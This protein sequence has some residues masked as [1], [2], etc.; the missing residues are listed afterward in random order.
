MFDIEYEEPIDVETFVAPQ[1]MVLQDCVVKHVRTTDYWRMTVRCMFVAPLKKIGDK[2]LC[3][4][5]VVDVTGAEIKLSGWND[6]ARA[7]ETGF[8][9]GA[10]YRVSGG[11]FKDHGKFAHSNCKFFIE[12]GKT[13]VF[14][15]VDM[16]PGFPRTKDFTLKYLNQVASVPDDDFV[17]VLVRAV[18][19]SEISE[20]SSKGT[21]IL[22]VDVMDQLEKIELKFFNHEA[23]DM[24]A[25]L[26]AGD[27]LLIKAAL[28]ETFKS[29]K[30]LSSPLKVIINPSDAMKQVAILKKYFGA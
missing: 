23:E 17:D 2:V 1:G 4:V 21:K 9:P 10:F 7:M 24:K 11:A 13:A 6:I 14:E 20:Y 3:N 28:V 19:V 16:P 26:T 5:L 12:M 29:K 27:F 15:R 22:T 25:K 8:K 18:K 30:Q